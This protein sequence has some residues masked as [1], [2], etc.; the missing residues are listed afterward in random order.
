MVVLA[1]DDAGEAA[2]GVARYALPHREDR[3]AGRVDHDALLLLELLDPVYRGAEGRQENHVFG[4]EAFER[5]LGG[6][7]EA[8][9]EELY[10]HLAQPVVHGGVVDHVPRDE[11]APVGELLARLEGVVHGPVDPV[12]EPEL[13]GEPDR[14]PLGLEEVAVLADP[15]DDLGAVVPVQ[16]M[17]DVLPHLEAFSEVFLLR[18]AHLSC[19]TFVSLTSKPSVTH[20]PRRVGEKC[21]AHHGRRK[22]EMGVKSSAVDRRPTIMVADDDP[23]E[24]NAPPGRWRTP[25]TA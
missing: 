5:L 7:F 21:Y 19:P 11:D 12:A 18:H 6:A 10:P 1:V 4:G 15:V 2:R 3:P 8:G 17:L 22:Y 13:V 16:K 23:A 14:E 20:S 24:L 25:A 9:G